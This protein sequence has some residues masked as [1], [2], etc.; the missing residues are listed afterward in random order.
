MQY[1]IPASS[2]VPTQRLRHLLLEPHP[3]Q[4]AIR[5]VRPIETARPAPPDPAAAVARQCPPAPAASPS[6]CTRAARIRGNR[7]RN[8][9]SRRYS[10][11]KS[12]PHWLMQCASSI[13]NDP[14]PIRSIHDRNPS[15]SSRSGAASSSLTSP[16]STCRRTSRASSYSPD[17]CAA[18]P[19]DTPRAAAHPPD[20]SSAQSAATPPRTASP[21]AAAA[22]GSTATSRRPSASPPAS[23]DP[24]DVAP[25]ASP[26]SGRSVSNPQCRRTTSM[27]RASS[28]AT[29]STSTGRSN[30]IPDGPR[31]A[32]A[33]V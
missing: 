22:P 30:R 6:P 24:P 11:R 19:P 16:R 15:V 13:A 32:M 29:L 4:H 8:S 14:T 17:C 1:T 28:F 23:P 27:I 12:C 5:Q 33:A 31:T 10:G 9:A 2:L 21:S 18:P 7:S 3:R 26:C 20:P 25:I